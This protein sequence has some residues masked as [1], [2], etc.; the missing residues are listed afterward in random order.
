MKVS[1][2]TA[3]AAEEPPDLPDPALAEHTQVDP[4]VAPPPPDSEPP[5]PPEPTSAAQQAV[6]PPTVARGT[7]PVAVG[8]AGYQKRRRLGTSGMGVVHLASHA[9]R[10]D[11]WFALKQM[12]EGYRHLSF[13]RA[14][15]EEEARLALGLRHPHLVRTVERGADGEGPWLVMEYVAGPAGL[16]E[17]GWPDDLPPPPLSL[18]QRVD[19]NG[20]LTDRQV[21]DLGVKLGSAVEAMHAAGVLHG[22]IKPLNVL[23]DG[24]G[25]PVLIDLGLARPL[26]PDAAAPPAP[27]SRIVSIYY[28]APEVRTNPACT[29]PRV[30][31]YAL[32]GTLIY[33]LTRQHPEFCPA[34]RIPAGLRAVLLQAVARKPEARYP[35]AAAFSAALANALAGP[36]PAQPPAPAAPP[37]PPPAAVTSSLVIKGHRPAGTA[38]TAAPSPTGIRIRGR[39][40]G[41]QQP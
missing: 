41:P 27:P 9:Y 10:R 39:R 2:R 32:G 35:S 7:G 38:G 21:A 15:F 18:Q 29:D 14:R 5:R 37:L 28:A 8:E 22:D 4:V 23:L 24:S 34:E 13:L 25:Q 26:H 17:P 30:D 31:V 16:T 11:G 40:P 12:A 19:R 36:A 6:A 20:V 33:A 1:R 3:G